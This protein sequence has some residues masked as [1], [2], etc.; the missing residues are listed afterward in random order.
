[1][2]DGQAEINGRVILTN[3]DAHNGAGR[4]LTNRTIDAMMN[5]LETLGLAHKWT[6]VW[7]GLNNAATF[8]PEGTAGDPAHSRHVVHRSAG[9]LT[10]DEVCEALNAAY[11]ENLKTPSAHTA[12]LWEGGKLIKTAEDQ[13]ERHLKG[14]LNL[15]FVGRS[16]QVKVLAQTPVPSGRTDLIFLQQNQAGRQEIAGVL[17]LKALRGPPSMDWSATEEGLS[18]GYHYRNDFQLPFATLALYDLTQAPTHDVTALLADQNAEH[19]SVVRTRRFPIYKTAK[20][21]RD[22]GGYVAT[23]WIKSDS[24]DRRHIA[25]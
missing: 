17:E 5:D 3:R 12:K 6:L 25:P 11:N 18:Q 4:A 22:A 16:R 2:Q 8:Y 9:T 24:W 21:W 19:V 7:D 23:Y 13:I 14:E 15:F 10:Q 1:M 20:Q